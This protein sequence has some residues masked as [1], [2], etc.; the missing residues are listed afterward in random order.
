MISGDKLFDILHIA[1]ASIWKFLP[2][3][4]KD[5]SLIERSSSNDEKQSL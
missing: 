3:T 5:L 4:V 2:W 1:V